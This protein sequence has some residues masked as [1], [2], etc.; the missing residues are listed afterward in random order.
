MDLDI[1]V[2]R[3]NTVYG[4]YKDNKRILQK[5]IAETYPNRI[6]SLTERISGLEKDIALAESNKTEDFVQMTVD[7]KVYT[8]KKDAATAFLESCRQIRPD[9][10]EKPVGSYKG[11][12]LS[13]SFDS[14]SKCFKVNVKNEIS[15]E[16]ELSSDA[17]GNLTRLENTLKNIPKKLETAKNSLAE[18]KHNLEIAKAEVDKPFPQL[19]ELREKEE[20]L[21]YL[22]KELSMEN[23]EVTEDKEEKDKGEKDMTSEDIAI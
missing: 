11:F 19:E 13:A 7:G 20:R 14:F 8:D 5:N 2:S 6:Q 23:K 10:K 21:A 9:Q 16:F 12:T 18:V 1:E 3:L 22:N 4:A 17:F 15:H